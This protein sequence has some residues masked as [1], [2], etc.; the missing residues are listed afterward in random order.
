M[1]LFFFFFCLHHAA[2]GILVPRPEI[3]P[4]P[5][6]LEARSLNHWTAKEVPRE[7]MNWES[8]DLTFGSYLTSL[9]LHFYKIEIM[10]TS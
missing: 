2:C 10:Y 3:E 8:A 1:K 4:E 9:S 5:P 6:E 7:S